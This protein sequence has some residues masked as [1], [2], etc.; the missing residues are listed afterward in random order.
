MNSL[1]VILGPPRSFT[2][3]VSAMLGQ[4]PQMYGLPEVHLFGAE[5]IAEWWR[6]VAKATF[7]MDHGLMR[8]SHSCFS[9]IK[10]RKTFSARPAG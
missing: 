1:L 4:H 10:P 5:T 8:V 3:V 6:H 2:T 7:N 9:A